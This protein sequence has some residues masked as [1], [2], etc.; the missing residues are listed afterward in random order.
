MIK[1]PYVL[2]EVKLEEARKKRLPYENNL[3]SIPSSLVK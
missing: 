1:L 2:L 3:G